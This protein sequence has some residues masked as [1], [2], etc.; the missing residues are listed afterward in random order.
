[1]SYEYILVLGSNL[2]DR[3][4]FIQSAIKKLKSAGNISISRE[5]EEVTTLPRHIKNQNKF[6]N[7]GLLVK[8]DLHPVDLLKCL[9]EIEK[10]IGRL[11]TYHHGPREI[12]IDIV[13]WSEGIYFDHNL[14]I[15]HAYN[16]A[17]EWVRRFIGEFA[18]HS[19]RYTISKIR[20][21]EMP[22][23]TVY[24]TARFYPEKAEQRT[25]YC[26]HLL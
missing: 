18:P 14:E 16:R 6:K 10:S 22:T 1:M 8:T 24:T 7:K 21:S 13:W 2:G 19:E 20:Y 12:D 15:P 4:F 5:T 26:A 23:K 17:R 11:N 25:Y 3:S 9:K